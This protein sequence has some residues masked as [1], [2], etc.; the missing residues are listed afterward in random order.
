M[1]DDDAP[2]LP[3]RIPG[4]SRSGIVQGEPEGTFTAFKVDFIDRADLPPLRALGGRRPP[5]PVTRDFP[6]AIPPAR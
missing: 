2:P 3:S 6:E 1:S 4:R 5:F